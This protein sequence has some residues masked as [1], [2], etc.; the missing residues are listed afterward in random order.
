MTCG[1]LVE[2]ET[3]DQRRMDRFI[4]ILKNVS[5]DPVEKEFLISLQNIIVEGRYA[6]KD[7]RTDQVYVGENLTPNL[8]KVH[9]I[10]VKPEDVAGIMRGFLSVLNAWISVPGG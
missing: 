6:Q 7:W 3:P 9:F 2:R 1:S 8:E 10:G 5:L 4:S